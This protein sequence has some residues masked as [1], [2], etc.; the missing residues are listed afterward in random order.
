MPP[1]KTPE[2]EEQRKRLDEFF[3]NTLSSNDEVRKLF[4][5]IKN[6]LQQFNLDSQL[7]EVEIFSETYLR[8]RKAIESGKEILNLPGWINRT[9]YNI[10]R[11]YSKKEKNN[12]NLHSKLITKNPQ[13][14][15]ETFMKT[16]EDKE[17]QIS[18]LCQ[19]KQDLTLEE[20]TLLNF[21]HGEGVSWKEIR[22]RRG[23]EKYS[24]STLRK[25]GERALK[26]LRLQYQEKGES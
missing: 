10:I 20:S 9:A 14:F 21:R 25:K 17:E 2:L 5:F 4:M 7:D 13:Q 24:E 23:F 22:K 12:Q 3:Q 18:K 8:A 1:D 16:A 6:K 15:E 26:K 19:A 11:E